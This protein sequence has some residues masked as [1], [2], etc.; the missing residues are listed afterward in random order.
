MQHDFLYLF[1]YIFIFYSIGFTTLFFFFPSVLKKHSFFIHFGLAWAL[2][3]FVGVV[4]FYV[5][6]FINKLVIV[7]PFN[8]FILYAFLSIIF[9]IAVY[10][11]KTGIKVVFD[12]RRKI[13]LIMCILFL[14]FFFPLLKNALFSYLIDWDSTAIWLLKAKAFFYAEGVW[15]TG[16]FN[17]QSLF[18]YANKAYPIGFP[19]LIAGYYTLIGRVNDQAVQLYI[20]L[21]YLNLVFISYGFFRERIRTLY[22]LTIFLI[23]ISLFIF[24][25]MIIY[26][27]NGFADIP[28]SFIF[29]LC[30]ILCTYICSKEKSI[31]SLQYHALIFIISGL[32]AT[33][34]NEGIA[35]FIIINT[36]SLFLLFFNQTRHHIRQLNLKRILTITTVS[37][38]VLLPL[39]LWQYFIRLNHIETDSYL[40]N[41]QL[42]HTMVSRVKLIF[43]LYLNEIIN[44]SKYGVMLIPSFFLFVVEYTFLIAGKK[45]RSL[46][47]SLVLIAQLGAYTLIYAI[48][49]VPLDWQVLTSFDRLVLHL[50]PGFYVLLIYQWTPTIEVIKNIMK[51]KKD[52][53]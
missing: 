28:L 13:T 8:V 2:G 39:V 46:I 37:I 33:I 11:K 14:I 26:A 34:K 29:T 23:V 5:L 24:P 47:P 49:R 30:V 44:A 42:Y 52:Y 35:F 43:N 1:L 6:A 3:N 16:F 27:H 21:F 40:H 25:Y 53:I 48:T 51:K 17:D 36:L 18:Y 7:T 41:A 12:K 22:S 15:N 9:L 45:I 38:L 50:I 20:S 19:L 32:G 10:K 4:V 31:H